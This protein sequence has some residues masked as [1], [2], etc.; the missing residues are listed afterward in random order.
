MLVM[1]TRVK[2]RLRYYVKKHTIS[3]I[4]RELKL[5]RN[6]VKRIIR[7][8][9]T[10][11]KKYKRDSQPLPKLGNFKS[12]LEAFL[13]EDSKLQKSERC[14]SRKLYERLK[15]KGYLG[16]YDSVQRFVKQW[17]LESGKIGDA[18][19]PLSFAPGEA[20]QFDWSEETVELGGIVQ[21]VKVAHFRLCH[22]RLFY[23]VSYP[24]ETQEM[25]FDAHDRAFR[26]FKGIPLRGIY[27]N[28]KT[29]VDMVFMGKDR[30]FN[31][32][33]LEMQN[34]YLIEPTA[35]SPAAGWEKGQV[36]NQVGNMREWVF[37]PRLSF[38][39]L[40]HLNAHLE[41]SCLEQAKIRK[42]PE[43]RDLSIRQVFDEQEA[44]FLRPLMPAFEGYKEHS[45]KVS[46]TCLVGFDRNRYSVDCHYANQVVSLRAYAT[47]I[48]IMAEGKT[49]A[50][51]TRHFGRDKTLFDPWHYVPLLK[52]KPGAL[53][54]GAPFQDWGLPAPL[55]KVRHH[56]TKHSGGDRECVRVLLA[57]GIYGLETVTVACELAI[58]DKV[59][60][61]DYILN[62][63]GR[64]S[65]P[66]PCK[67]IQ[68]PDMLKLAHEPVANCRL[69]NTLLKREV[70]Y[71]TH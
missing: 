6:T 46:S 43:Y 26:F 56:L 49:I 14:S 2:I 15:I 51:H 45:C 27:D 24:R 32:R 33:F 54:N 47:H 37:V 18:Y 8:E 66:A 21:K 63:V 40:A 65:S 39:D 48:V 50:T 10:R 7:E 16:A 25:L 64:L 11:D 62:L 34:H 35:C 22:S 17:Q 52:R 68:T 1:E 41:A 71:A 4:S 53:R 55:Q 57:I 60:S 38:A 9:D 36:E 23:M 30:K 59:I 58:Q 44:S 20:Y 13:T 31:R 3:Q 5:S 61:A 12:Q 19:I 69:Y 42:H 70:S 28:M 67:P 29:A